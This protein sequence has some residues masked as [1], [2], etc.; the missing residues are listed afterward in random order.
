M[1][2]NATSS[3]SGQSA[4]ATDENKKNVLLG[5]HARTSESDSLSSSTSSLKQPHQKRLRIDDLSGYEMAD[6]DSM[7][8]DYGLLPT[9][10][11]QEKVSSLLVLRKFGEYLQDSGNV[12]GATPLLH[13]PTVLLGTSSFAH[14]VPGKLSESSALDLE[15]PFARHP[16]VLTRPR[17]SYSMCRIASAPYEVPQ[18]PVEKQETRR[19]LEKQISSNVKTSIERTLSYSE[20]S[21]DG[22]PRTASSFHPLDKAELCGRA[23]FIVDQPA[24]GQGDAA[25][26]SDEGVTNNDHGPE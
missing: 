22:D 9:S 10:P 26:F 8:R 13:T 14:S 5:R 1:S 4:T 15:E 6:D 23:F 17:S 21:D 7:D 16:A 11:D 18:Y 3:A 19:A 2:L 12:N 25:A 20:R 24:S